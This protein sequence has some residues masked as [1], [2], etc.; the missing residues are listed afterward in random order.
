MDE[1]EERI[2]AAY[3]ARTVDELAQL[4]NDLSS[5]P[6]PVA[7]AEPERRRRKRRQERSER[8]KAVR[9]PVGRRGAMPRRNCLSW[10]ANTE[11]NRGRTSSVSPVRRS[12][13]R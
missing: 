8:K 4:T 13:P 10:L 5:P 3:S 11:A 6:Q 12:S 9:L 7:A 1:F 2:A